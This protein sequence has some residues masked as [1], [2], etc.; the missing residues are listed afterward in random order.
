ME[1][2]ASGFGF[3][4]FYYLFG[5]IGVDALDG[6]RHDQHCLD[7]AHAVVIVVLRLGLRV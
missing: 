7:G 4:T 3:K 5:H 1:V 6:A 2:Q